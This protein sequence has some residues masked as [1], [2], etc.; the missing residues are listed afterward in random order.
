MEE[1][2][3]LGKLAV[4]CAKE[5]ETA[6]RDT[7]KIMIKALQT[8][9]GLGKRAYSV[10]DRETRVSREEAKSLAKDALAEIR[11][12]L[13]GIRREIERMEQEVKK[14]VRDLEKALDDLI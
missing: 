6:A 1:R 12:E 2:S 3:E 13:P 7:E 14:R 10:I 4:K 11:K 8:A 5:L 9:E